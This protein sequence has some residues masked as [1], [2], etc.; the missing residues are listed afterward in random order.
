M[1][2]CITFAKLLQNI[3]QN[4]CRTFAIFGTFGAF[5]TFGTFGTCNFCRTFAGLLQDFCRT[6]AE[7]LELLESQEFKFNK[8]WLSID[9][10]VGKCIKSIKLDK[11]WKSDRKK[12]H[13]K[14]FCIR[15]LNTMHKKDLKF[16]LVVELLQ[17][18]F[19]YIMVLKWP[20]LGHKE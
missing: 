19:T 8:S 15:E 1:N 2:L 16:A 4:F 10:C 6:F 9:Q 17:L 3:L 5:G 13:I 18:K 11:I 14:S 12:K 20:K 7:L